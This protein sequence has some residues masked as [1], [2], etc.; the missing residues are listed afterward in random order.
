MA[1]IQHVHQ[2]LAFIKDTILQTADVVID[3]ALWSC[4]GVIFKAGLSCVCCV[5]GDGWE[6]LMALNEWVS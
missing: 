4:E 5:A 6:D 2:I 3:V 1:A